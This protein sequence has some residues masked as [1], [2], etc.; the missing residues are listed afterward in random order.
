MIASRTLLSDVIQ[1][2]SRFT[3]SVNLERDFLSEIAQEGYV[4][5][6]LSRSTILRIAEG[7]RLKGGTR[8]WTL[9]G[10][11]GS[12]KSAFALYIAGLFAQS[13][14]LRLATH[15]HLKSNDPE[16]WKE[17]FDQRRLT[18]I[19]PCSLLPVLVT[20]SR[21]SVRS[22]VGSALLRMLDGRRS[23]E[24]TELTNQLRDYLALPA[25]QQQDR[26]LLEL[27]ERLCQQIVP[28][29]EATGLLIVLDELGKYLEHAALTPANGDL[30][31]LQSLAELAQRSPIPILFVTLLH[32]SFDRYA[33]RLTALERSEWSKVQGRFEDVAFQESYEQNVRLIANALHRDADIHD[34]SSMESHASQLGVKAQELGLRPPGLGETEFST[35]LADCAPL[36]PL[37]ALLLGP[38][39][40]KLAQNE[41]SLFAFLSSKEPEGF[42]D[43]L[44]STS[45]D[46]EQSHTYNLDRLYDYLAASF[47][48]N[49]YAT[50]AGGRWAEI[51]TALDRLGSASPEIEK[52]IVKCVGILSLVGNLGVLKPDQSVLSFATSIELDVLNEILRKLCE[53][54]VLIFRN[55]KASYALW[56]GSDFDL[57][58][59]LQDARDNF[60]RGE[61][62]ADLLEQ[63]RPIRPLVA[64]KHSAQYGVL[65]YF[66]VS[67]WDIENLGS[68]L[69]LDCG[70]ADGKLVLLI[71]GRSGEDKTDRLLETLQSQPQVLLG[72]PEATRVLHGYLQDLRAL[73]NVLQTCPEL[74]GDAVARREIRAR[75]QDTQQSLRAQMDSLLDQ[76]TARGQWYYLG[77]LVS[78]N[79]RRNLTEKLSEICSK[80]YY[81][82][83]VIR[84]EMVHRRMLSSACSA[85]RNSLIEA[86]LQRASQPNLGIV[87]HPLEKSLYD[88][89]LSGPGIHREDEGVWGFH[90][91]NPEHPD[92]IQGL[93]NAFWSKLEVSELTRTSVDDL[94]GCV[95]LAPYGVKDGPLPILLCAFLLAHDMEL[96]MYEDGAFVP[97]MTMSHYER[98]VRNPGRF[99]IQRYRV[100][101]ARSQVF[102]S[103]AAAYTGRPKQDRLLTLVRP[104][105]QVVS[106]LV[107]Y[108]KVTRTVSEEACEVRRAVLD[109][110]DPIKLLFESLPQALGQNPLGNEVDQDEQAQQYVQTL[111]LKL[112]ELQNAYPNLL[113]RLEDAMF[114]ALGTKSRG[115]AARTEVVSRV[116]HLM[117]LQLEDSVLGVL[118]RLSDDKVDHQ[119]WVESF[120]TVLASKPPKHWVDKDEQVFGTSL[121]EFQRRFRQLEALSL[122]LGHSGRTEGAYCLS[123]LVPGKS[124]QEQVVVLLEE[125]KKDVQALKSAILQQ[126]NAGGNRIS[127]ETMLV[128]LAEAA[129]QLLELE[130]ATPQQQLLF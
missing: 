40:R 116:R 58:A 37:V 31:F 39:F 77:E 70:E 25:E 27:I 21:E 71:G 114:Q 81:R 46:D 102:A 98:L 20:G 82:T 72:I 127:R 117:K 121:L 26:T 126:Y 129:L 109:A 51:E 12:G 52:T 107:G 62:L 41:R 100:D 106:S 90:A 119:P 96:A 112:R 10:P 108:A 56:E 5:T 63:E 47:G 113:R 11:Y 83:P 7:L 89:L 94:F 95:R 79:S 28:Q 124:P 78:V 18:C 123:I 61:S 87:G 34:F 80:V 85:A 22:S 86:M 55:F 45:A 8:A 43:F 6:S 125:Q 32:Q 118:V 84:N 91:P 49:L 122:E 120:A 97:Q 36:H 48:S 44:R 16:L 73:R 74:A 76:V 50:S 99:H 66:G 105:F 67:Y 65:R 60:G 53:Q 69:S 38:L 93:W 19:E 33:E 3:R 54:S 42:Q 68:E 29:S 57:E 111:Q 9:T 115:E 88:S 101:G 15:R 23:Q 130:P 17:L 104:I 110:T 24:A 1:V 4:I 103:L 92:R 59:R 13:G 2:R 14:P 128:A 75:I 64:R 35:L 30:L